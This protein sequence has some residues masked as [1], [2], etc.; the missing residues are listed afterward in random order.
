MVN[1]ISQITFATNE[2]ALNWRLMGAF[3]RCARKQI[4][5]YGQIRIGNNKIT[6]WGDFLEFLPEKIFRSRNDKTGL[7][8]RGDQAEEYMFFSVF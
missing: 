7:T 2:S 1:A 5:K 4:E 3:I 8:T 6:S